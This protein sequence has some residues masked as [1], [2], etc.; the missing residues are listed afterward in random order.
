MSTHFAGLVSLTQRCLVYMRA[1]A[2]LPARPC[3]C[4][5]RGND[6]ACQACWRPHATL[7]RPPAM[8]AAGQ[9]S[10]LRTPRCNM[11]GGAAEENAPPSSAGKTPGKQYTWRAG[12]LP[13][14]LRKYPDTITVARALRMGPGPQCRAG[15]PTCLRWAASGAT[16]SWPRR[17][18]S[19]R[20]QPRQRRRRC[21]RARPAGQRRRPG[22]ARATPR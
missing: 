18:T 19:R 3:L 17:S 5:Y 10:R 16:W 9:R 13:G 1:P 6:R 14:N 20:A 8:P 12:P 21:Q 22:C 11:I 15:D 2:R 7:Q 4:S